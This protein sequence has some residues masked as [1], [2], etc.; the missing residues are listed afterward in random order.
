MASGFT[1]AQKVLAKA[2]P[3][4]GPDH[5]Q[6]AGLTRYDAF[7]EIRRARLLRGDQQ[8]LRTAAVSC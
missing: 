3:K 1:A 6:S 2:A 5:F 8:A 7:P 4:L